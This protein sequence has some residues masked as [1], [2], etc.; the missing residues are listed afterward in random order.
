MVTLFFDR[1]VG[2]R[3]PEAL[4][5]L[6]LPVGIQYHQEHFAQ[7]APDDV[8]LL[9]VGAWGWFIVGQDWSYHMNE[10]ELSAIKQYNIGCFYLWG[11]KE[12]MWNTMRCFARAY[13]RIIIAATTQPRPFIFRVTRMGILTRVSIP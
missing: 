5:L 4:R 3:L 2:R 10:S 13:D 8:W 11:A 7:D 12:P 9:E 1:S 6:R